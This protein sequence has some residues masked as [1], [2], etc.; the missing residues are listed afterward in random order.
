MD[1]AAEQAFRE[2]EQMLMD[3]V[4]LKTPD[5]VPISLGLNCIPARSSLQR[6]SVTVTITPELHEGE[7]IQTHPQ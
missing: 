2:R 3:A 5:R 1:Q 6:I 4:Q 7:L